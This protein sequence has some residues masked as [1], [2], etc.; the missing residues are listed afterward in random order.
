MSGLPE[1]RANPELLG[2]AGA[3][4]ELAQAMRSARM[5]HAWLILGPA[6]IG[7]A[8]LAFRAARRLLAGAP[9]GDNLALPPTHP[10]FRRVASGGH[11][12]LLTVQPAWDE[13]KERPRDT[14]RVDDVRPLPEFLHLTAA[15]GG[16]RVVVIDGADT[17]NRNA[18]NALLKAVEEPPPRTVLFLVCVA[19]GLLPVTLRSRCRR[20]QLRPL[21]D[22][23]VAALLARARPD[24][25]EAGRA[26]LARRAEGSIGRALDLANRD[27]VDV[28]A[29]V[30]RALREPLRLGVPDALAVAEAMKGDDTAFATFMDELRAGLAHAV[31]AAA[32]ARA[33]AAQTRLLG[34]R[35]LA[36]WVAVWQALGTLKDETVG[37]YLDKREALVQGFRMLVNGVP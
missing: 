16:W 4:A 6:G 3:E 11:A 27:G 1:P 17:L 28:P 32:R 26:T 19:Q 15:E 8:T 24:L 21:P 12:D 5:H 31:R 25:A 36:E 37:L 30:Q 14:L 29:L 10:V 33:D 2:H 34:E 18:A 23:D 20:L 9:A 13:D 7:K 35:G 22:A